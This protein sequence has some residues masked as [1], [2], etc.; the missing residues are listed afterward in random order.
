MLVHTDGDWEF[1]FKAIDKL[2]ETRAHGSVRDSLARG[3]IGSISG[4][5]LQEL[6]YL[7]RTLK[8]LCEE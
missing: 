3:Q 1:K 7:L 8:L 2:E 6:K 5:P 4:V